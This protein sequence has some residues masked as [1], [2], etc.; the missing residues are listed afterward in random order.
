MNH[1]YIKRYPPILSIIFLFLITLTATS[2][3]IAQQPDSLAQWL[4]NAKQSIHKKILPNGLTVLFYPLT[5][6]IDVDLKVIVNVGSRDEHEG[7]YGF[8]H[9]VE[10]MIFKGTEK[11]SETDIKR[12]SEKFN[13]SYNAFTEYDQTTYYFRTDNKNWHIFMDI[14]ADCMQHARF[15]DNHFASEVKTVISE[16]NMRR[17]KPTIKMF[18]TAIAISFPSTHPYQHPL[19]GTRENLVT[20]TGQDLKNFYH[21]HYTPDRTLV[22][23]VGNINKEEAF[24]K[25]EECFGSIPSNTPCTTTPFSSDPYLPT[26]FVQQAVTIHTHT[27]NPLSALFWQVPSAHNKEYLIGLILTYILNKRLEKLKDSYNLVYECSAMQTL[28]FDAGFFYIYFEPRID[29]YSKTLPAATCHQT[30]KT[31]IEHEINDLSLSGPT[32][33]ELS[34]A[35]ILSLNHMVSKLE[36]IDFIADVLAG[37]SLNHNEYQVFDEFEYSQNISKQD[38]KKFCQKYL[39]QQRANAISCVP[40]MNNEQEEWMERQNAVDGYEKKLLEKKQRETQLE[41]EKPLDQ[42]PNP[43]L[44]DFVFKHPD[45]HVTLSNGL[46]VYVKRQ[47]TTPALYLECCV[48]NPSKT[49]LWYAQNHQADLPSLAIELLPEGSTGTPEHSEDFTKKEHDDF[50][51]SLGARCSFGSLSGQ[52][53]C[54]VKDLEICY[55]RFI[56]ILTHPTYPKEVFQREVNENKE[57]MLA[58]QKNADHVVDSTFNQYLYKDYPW[59]FSDE[60]SIEDLTKLSIQDLVAFHK[61]WIRPST[62]YLV[63]V[64]NIDPDNAIQLL[65]KTCGSWKCDETDTTTNQLSSLTIPSITNPP[66]KE[67]SKPLPHEQTI[68]MTGRITAEKGTDEARALLLAEDYLNKILFEIREKT[69]LFY[70][71]RAHLCATSFLTKGYTCISTSVSSENAAD[72]KQGIKDVL[73]KICT[74]GIPADQIALA[75]QNYINDLAR[76]F[77]TSQQLCNIYSY[78]IDQGKPFTYYDE[79]IQHINDLSAERIND[80]VKEYLNPDHWTFVEGGKVNE[81]TA[82]AA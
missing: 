82:T 25:A 60:I 31:H 33:Q 40:L 65:E 79:Q 23:I 42:F 3:L 27:A 7:Q 15:D 58:Q 21:T 80:L 18:E 53:F 78:L 26:D 55:P 13:A 68:I 19:I 45:R 47:T 77:S 16:L 57:S 37:Y 5:S 56:H 35:K 46:E 20:A 69:G 81:Q 63:L 54:L 48:K 30:I 38:I 10:H 11:L 43:K 12:I 44:L 1:S 52:L 9:M 62:M 17:T 51:E 64:G 2:Q 61:Q 72:V 66:A 24:Q 32:A 76:S 75:K 71:C 49:Y 59:T 41:Q 28:L 50:F 36:N 70:T 73:R 74:E 39:Q 67:F 14:L 8:A 4:E 34:N 29:E 22:T 6:T